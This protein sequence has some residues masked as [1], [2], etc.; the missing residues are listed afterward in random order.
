MHVIWSITWD[1]DNKWLVELTIPPYSAVQK[2]CSPMRK[3]SD[4]CTP[5][6]MAAHNAHNYEQCV[7]LFTH[8]FLYCPILFCTIFD[9][10]CKIFSKVQKVK[11][12]SCK[13]L[14]RCLN[15]GSTLSKLLSMNAC[16][17]ALF[18]FKIDE[19]PN[20]RH[21]QTQITLQVPKFR[22]GIF[23]CTI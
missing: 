21:I 16:R 15:L 18:C 22:L 19:M 11:Q 12:I 20:F 7:L 3:N 17:F 10:L 2:H 4:Q 5:L 23:M 13:Y 8:Y 1:S 14:A 9:I 6:H